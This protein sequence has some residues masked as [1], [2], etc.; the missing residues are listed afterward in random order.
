MTAC[1]DVLSEVAA[2]PSQIGPCL[3]FRSGRTETYQVCG[4]ILLPVLGASE[5]AQ[6]ELSRNFHLPGLVTAAMLL[7][8]VVLWKTV[9]TGRP[10]SPSLP[11]GL[12][13]HPP[14]FSTI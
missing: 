14:M 1:G 13:S 3:G 2:N 12:P 6:F 11:W 9:S 4:L 5:L 7:A 8:P 10:F